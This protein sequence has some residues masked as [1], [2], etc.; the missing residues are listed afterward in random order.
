MYRDPFEMKMF[1]LVEL[2]RGAPGGVELCRR[3]AGVP[4]RGRIFERLGL[5]AGGA[6]G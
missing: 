3:L 1:P 2:V 5:Y 6:E 4:F